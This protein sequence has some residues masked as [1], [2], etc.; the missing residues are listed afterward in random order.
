MICVF[1]LHAPWQSASEVDM[2]DDLDDLTQS[3]DT[4][5]EELD[6]PSSGYRHASL[7]IKQFDSTSIGK[8]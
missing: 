7:L 4:R 8:T 1:L 3:S 6:S 5:S 2:A